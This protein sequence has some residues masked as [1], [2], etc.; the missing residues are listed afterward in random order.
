MNFLNIGLPELLVLGLI[1]LIVFGPERLPEEA[2]KAARWIRAMMRTETYREASALVKTVRDLP[3]KV[4][5]EAQ[6]EE[7]EKEIAEFERNATAPV[8]LAPQLFDEPQPRTGSQPNPPEGQ[9]SGETQTATDSYP[10][11]PTEAQA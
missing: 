8:S 4:M 2:K 6:I 1:L 5:Q 3:R 11:D 10:H 7:L 9:P